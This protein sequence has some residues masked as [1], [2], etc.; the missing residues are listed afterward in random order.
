MLR[1]CKYSH[2]QKKSMILILH[3]TVLLAGV[4][5]AFS[6][7]S[8]ISVKP[9]GPPVELVTSYICRA[10][11]CNRVVQYGVQR[12]LYCGCKTNVCNN[13][14]GICQ[15]TMHGDSSVERGARSALTYFDI[16]LTRKGTAY[17]HTRRY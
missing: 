3:R 2:N 1:I 12:Y 10:L 16:R 13:V 6:P 4:L 17:M 9:A 8:G 11:L 5:F 14:R 15:R 7:I